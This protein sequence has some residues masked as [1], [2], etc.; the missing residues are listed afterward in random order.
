MRYALRSIGFR[1]L[2]LIFSIIFCQELPAQGINDI[3]M[4]EVDKHKVYLFGNLVDIQNTQSFYTALEK[5]FNSHKVNFSVI[6]A[7]D[8]TDKKKK[9]KY[10]EQLQ[11]VYE[12]MD[13][14]AK[15]ERGRLICIPGDRDWNLGKIG[16]LKQVNKLENS[17][18]DYAEEHDI[19]N[20][21]FP[22]KNGCPGPFDLSLDEHIEFVGINTQWWNTPIDKPTLAD[23]E[24]KYVAYQNVKEE[25]DDIIDDNRSKNV[26]LVGHHPISSLGNYG[27]RFS[28]KDHMKPFPIV[29]TIENSYKMSVGGKK[30][31][32]NERFILFQKMMENA[33]FLHHDLIYATAHE[34]NQQL[35]QVKDNYFMNSG[36]V[37][38]GSY[39][40]QDIY[41]RFSSSQGGIMCI[42]YFKLGK[43]TN[44]FLRFDSK[45]ARFYNE[46]QNDLFL[47]ACNI[48]DIQRG[49]PEN[50][51]HVPCF[52]PEDADKDVIANA[53]VAANA[54]MV[55]TQAGKKYK[56]NAFTEL[57]FGKHY[58]RDWAAPI[59]VPVLNIDTTFNGLKPK[60]RGGGRQTLSLKFLSQSGRQ[61]TF[62]SV[63]K[64]PSKALD[65][66]LR[67]SIIARLF[68]DQ[69]SA[70]QPFGSLIISRL[71]D[72]L[73]I[74]HARPKLYVMPDAPALGPFQTKY[75][76]LLGTLEE[77]PKKKNKKGEYFGKAD[78]IVKSNELFHELY[79]DKTRKIASQEFLR[80]RIFDILVGDWSKHEDNWKWAEYKKD[81]TKFYRPIPR[82]RDMVFSKWDGIFPYLAD[83]PFGAP[84]TEGFRETIKGFTS[85]VYQARYMDR[86]LLTEMSEEDYVTQAKF[87]QER[88]T[89][90]II[91]AAIA[92]LPKPS[93]DLSGEGIKRK[94]LQRKKDLVEH[95]RHYYRWLNGEVQVV[96]SVEDDRFDIEHLPNGDVTIIIF[97]GENEKVY[98]RTFDKKQTKLV[99]VYGLNGDDAFNIKG[100]KSKSIEVKLFGG[101]GE[102]EYAGNKQAK[103][104]DVFDNQNKELPPTDV[105]E[106][107]IV[108]NKDL[109]EYRRDRPIRYSDYLPLVSLGVNRFQGITFSVG[110]TWT[111]YK[112][113]KK[114]FASKHKV[115]ANLSSRG[116]V[117]LSYN[118]LWST[119]IR[120]WDIVSEVIISNPEYFNSFY[121]IGNETSIG[122]R[123]SNSDFFVA[124]YNQY[125]AGVGVGR[126]FWRNS[127]A[128]FLAGL[129][130]YKS[131]PPLGS[132]LDVESDNIFGAE[133]NLDLVFNRNELDI[134]L[135]DHKTLPYRGMR[136]LINNDNYRRLGVENIPKPFYG[137]VSGSVSYYISTYTR[138]KLTL[139]LRAG[140]TKGYGDIPYYHQAQLGGNQFL[141]GYTGNRFFGTSSLYINTELRMQVLDRPQASIP[142]KFG[143]IAF[144]DRGRVYSDK[145]IGKA[146]TGFKQG[147]G[148]G[149]FITPYS[150]SFTL[151]VN[152]GFSE[153]E[154]FNPTITLGSFLK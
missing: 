113:N 99:R 105:F 72:T 6:V 13:L 48:H 137:T 103:K 77:N 80:A 78:D 98:E 134:N 34:K 88:L 58:R 93:Y 55:V 100:M 151:S 30:D 133:G 104:I 144:Y 37:E 43:V 67:K 38:K 109:Y 75:G 64:D 63:D 66:T 28:F 51:S 86:F 23:A 110:N 92:R 36:A 22:V 106:N 33:I 76:G 54:K 59:R 101:Q 154:N 91:D 31:L 16:G 84:N 17:L 62:R 44:D 25:I 96:G 126:R 74:L 73:D 24:C 121:G 56:K 141:R 127:S 118:G 123:N 83:L 85:A 148:G 4:D 10:D 49:V 3:N 143:L 95:A 131:D 116:T 41:S 147:Y 115:S 7:G 117:G 102:D 150:R 40:A 130:R 29:G 65:Y 112:W 90:D 2:L 21:D 107:K 52:V 61:Y 129:G 26:L 87:I 153:E 14:V 119:V 5:E 111:R 146:D 39:A 46:Q 19:E 132:I 142:W 70:Q 32:S 149:F 57:F 139:G 108:R 94:L 120:R 128:T 47:S 9:K 11:T 68:R 27:G 18:K 50:S 97:T 35:S 140:G 15:Y 145:D 8:L 138:E 12:L 136:F 79:E 45:L 114:D 42:T 125:S 152:L 89:E 20:F 69:T 60:E 82:D 122:N 53:D 71:L 81:D 1:I 135:L 124:N